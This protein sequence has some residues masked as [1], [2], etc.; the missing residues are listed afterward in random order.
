VTDVDYKN[1]NTE[2]R[3]AA[4]FHV[5]GYQRFGKADGAPSMQTVAVVELEDGRM[6]TKRPECITF[7]DKGAQLAPQPGGQ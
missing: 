4:T 7:T 1:G 6:T 2:R 3:R 5:W